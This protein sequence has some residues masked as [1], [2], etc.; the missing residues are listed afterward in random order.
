MI[1]WLRRFLFSFWEHV[2]YFHFYVTYNLLSIYYSVCSLWVYLFFPFSLSDTIILKYTG[3]INWNLDWN[4]LLTHCRRYPLADNI[5][6]IYNWQLLQHLDCTADI[7]RLTLAL[8]QQLQLMRMMPVMVLRWS[9]SVGVT[10]KS[11][12]NM[13]HGRSTILHWQTANVSHSAEWA[14]KTA[15]ISK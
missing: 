12:L 9:W 4:K 14:T 7:I 10:R 2:K 15:L 11:G 1:V 13:L 6:L 3:L 8:D 5:Q